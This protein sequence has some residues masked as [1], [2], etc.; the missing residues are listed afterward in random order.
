[1]PVRVIVGAQWGDEG[2]GKIVDI[3]SAG[4]DIVA[5]YQGGANAGHTICH[6]QKKYVLHLIPSGILHQAVIAVIGN[7]VV[8]DPE[9]L[10]GE[11]EQLE[12]N[13]ISVEERLFIS[14]HVHIV[15][16]YHKTLDRIKEEASGEAQIGTTRRGIGPAYTDKIDRRGIR[17]IDLMEEKVVS[18]KIRFHLEDKKAL[19][20]T[21]TS[22]QW[23]LKDLTE[24]SI[25]W[26][27]RLRSFMRDT[28]TLLHEAV[29]NQKKILLEGAQGTLLD[30]DHGSYPYVT[31]SNAT[32]GG[33]CTGLGIPPNCI[34][35]VTGIVKAYT[36]RVGQGPFPTEMQPTIGQ[37]IREIGS[38]FGAT[39]GRPR[40]CGWLDLVQL[41]NATMINGF[42]D[43]AITKMDVLDGFDE[44]KV[45]TAYQING[46]IADECIT[47]AHGLSRV[48]PIYETL[49]GW[50]TSISECRSYKD[51]PVR[52]KDYLRFI[53]S[54]L[55]GPKI[56][57]ISVG[58]EREQTIQ[59]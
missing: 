24:L 27:Q 49:P 13:G 37:K 45:C 26:G 12:Q 42:T 59:C 29:V 21:D 18:E 3:L 48:T 55:A 10:F 11:I 43:L 41:K 46:R 17:L 23:D 44:I 54:F 53:E 5:R 22:Q 20:S 1:M 58:P 16:P 56:T 25:R 15:M 14:P 31:S 9:A 39:T 34:D 35:T 50:G 33:A 7:G 47:D 38:E 52:A 57:I 8:L 36:T 28:I 2:K 40:R 4:S 32:S 51:L 19:L 6:G 30:I